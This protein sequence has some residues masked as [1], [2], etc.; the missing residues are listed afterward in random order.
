MKQQQ[1]HREFQFVLPSLSRVTYAKLK[2]M[3]IPEKVSQ[4]DLV[5]LA[6]HILDE[7]KNKNPQVGTE[8]GLAFVN[9]VFE[10]TSKL[11]PSSGKP[12]RKSNWMT[13]QENQDDFNEEVARE[14]GES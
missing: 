8:S 1:P 11:S 9:R 3:L 4:W 7:L 14:N 5:T 6:I 13:S 2:T 10:D 12:R